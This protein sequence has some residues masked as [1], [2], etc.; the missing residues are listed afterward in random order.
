MLFVQHSFQYLV[1]SNS[2]GNKNKNNKRGPKCVV[3]LSAITELKENKQVNRV[4]EE[5]KK[6]EKQQI[7]INN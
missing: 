7:K 2:N 1:S 3:F 4:K 5:K 6:K